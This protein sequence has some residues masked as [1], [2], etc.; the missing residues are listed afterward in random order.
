MSFYHKKSGYGGDCDRWYEADYA[1]SGRSTCKEFR[2][3]QPIE[4][5]GLRIGIKSE[6]TEYAARSGWG[7]ATFKL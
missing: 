1:K 5:G 4:E 7:E 2:C 3:K 6:A